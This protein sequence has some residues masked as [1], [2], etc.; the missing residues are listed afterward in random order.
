MMKVSTDIATAM[1]IR[2][3]KRWQI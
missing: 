2:S 3:G 1:A